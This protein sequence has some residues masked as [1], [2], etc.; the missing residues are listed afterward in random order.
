MPPLAPATRALGRLRYA[1]K[2]ALIGVIILATI[3]F[4]GVAYL[5]EVSKQIDFSAKERVGVVYVA[6][7]ARLAEA[8]GATAKCRGRRGRGPSRRRGRGG[9]V[10]RYPRR[11]GRSAGRR[12]ARGQPGMGQAAPRRGVTEPSEPA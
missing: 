7:A 12:A 8:L 6:P 4:V 2:F 1:Y 10:R 11:C 3:G 5:Q 9:A